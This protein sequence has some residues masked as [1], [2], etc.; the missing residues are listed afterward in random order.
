MLCV[1]PVLSVGLI[2]ASA[3]YACPAGI[4]PGAPGCIPPSN[5]ASPLYSG[6]GASPQSR[7]VWA[8]RWGA[9][10]VDHARF[11]VGVAE[12]KKSKRKAIKAAEMDCRAKGGEECVSKKVYADQ[13]VVLIRGATGGYVTA[14]SGTI[15][16]AVE[17]AMPVCEEN[18]NGCHIYYSGCS[19]A[20]RIR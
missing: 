10:A 2:C 16:H 7:A 8:D 9:I 4:P 20:V 13:C 6:S 11:V 15:E 17:G 19:E 14:S 18:D 1:A 12:D 5:N 3:A